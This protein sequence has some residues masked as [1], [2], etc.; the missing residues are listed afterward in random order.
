MVDVTVNHQGRHRRPPKP[1]ELTLRPRAYA[2]VAAVFVVGLLLSGS[3]AAIAHPGPAAAGEPVAVPDHRVN[4]ADIPP[5]DPDVAPVPRVL[6]PAAVQPTAE[7]TAE[8]TAGPAEPAKPWTVTPQPGEGIIAVV[9]RV[10]GTSDTWRANALANGLVGPLW[11]LPLASELQVD[12]QA[13]PV[14]PDVTENL[15][16]TF[17]T[18]SVQYAAAIP[19]PSGWMSPLPGSCIV[20]GY[21]TAARPTHNG[22][23]LAADSGTPIYAAAAG[24]VSVAYQAGG[25][26]N[27]TVI[28]H[29]GVWTVYMHQSAY[30]VTSGWVEA[31]QVIGYVGSTGDSSGPHLH[32]EV[33]TALWDVRIDP[34]P[35]MSDRGV[36]WGWC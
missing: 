19:A 22:L 33:H 29:G 28:D 13:A 24:T 18:P 30:E 3:F 34:G 2:A 9:A 31:G 23:D 32:F 16:D 25:A 5:A 15:P 8:P 7:P 6:T 1:I 17:A 27:Y 4:P 35:W 11:R 26:G 21:R 12:C 14:A 36:G 20:S 10:C